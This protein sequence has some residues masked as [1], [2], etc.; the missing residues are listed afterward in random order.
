[1]N[2][3]FTSASKLLLGPFSRSPSLALLT[4]SVLAGV[5]TTIVF[6]YVSNQR[7]LRAAADR[8]RAMLLRM[9]LFKDDLHVA[10]ECQEELL[11]AIGLRL[12]HSFKPMVVLII[13]FFFVLTHLALLFEH[14]PLQENETAV[15]ELHVAPSFW[16]GWKNAKLEAPPGVQAE[17]P[18]LRDEKEHSV[19]WRLR[20]KSP[21][22]EPLRWRAGETVVEKQFLGAEDTRLLCAVSAERPG[23]RLWDRLLHPGEPSLGHD[24]PVR[25]VVVDYPKRVTPVLGLNLRWWATFLIVSMLSALLV[26]P[27]LRVQF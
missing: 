22:S 2:A 11:K 1:M 24:S 5:A 4:F 7:A 27:F 21:P 12:L 18:G 25:A 17:T 20:L 3:I 23:S 26:R 6:R 8:A 14:R 16:P 13:P 9:R 19:S 15:V 10:I